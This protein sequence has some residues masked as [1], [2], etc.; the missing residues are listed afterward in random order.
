VVA[1]PVAK[2]PLAGREQISEEP[3]LVTSPRPVKVETPV[4]VESQTVTSNRL[5]DLTDGPKIA[6][7]LR[8]AR[9]AAG[10]IVPD[11][12]KEIPAASEPEK[13]AVA[14]EPEKLRVRDD[15]PS[16]SAAAASGANQ[17]RNES[18][19]SRS[20]VAGAR[21]SREARNL[22]QE[23][24]GN[25][26]PAGSADRVTVQV[27]DSEGRQTRIRVSVLGDQVRAV[28]VPPDAESARQ[29]EQRMDDLQTALARQGF[30]S[31][32][33]SVQQ[34][35]ENAVERS[36]MSLAGMVSGGEGKAASPGREQPAGDQRQGRGQREQQHPGDGHRHPNGRSRDH[37]A[38]HRRRHSDA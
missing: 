15:R 36:G 5:I 10:P 26:R 19:T 7:P 24:P 1:A 22:P 11:V 6:E 25:D 16:D 31:S 27:S 33:V 4:R 21:E 37:E 38:E 23:D 28:I 30:A 29:L 3:V 14:V 13:K 2:A 35:G 34:A 20:E 18:L 8:E 12:R 9:A 17:G 32:K